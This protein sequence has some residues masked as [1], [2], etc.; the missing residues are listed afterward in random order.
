MARIEIA[1]KV[2]NINCE[3]VENIIWKFVQSAFIPKEIIIPHIPS[4]QFPQLESLADSI[5]SI[6]ISVLVDNVG[7]TNVSKKK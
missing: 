3:E 5:E 7:S 2:R 6:S 1:K 4:K